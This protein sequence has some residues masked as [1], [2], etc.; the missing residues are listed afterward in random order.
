MG[1]GRCSISGCVFVEVGVYREVEGDGGRGDTACVLRTRRPPLCHRD[2][3]SCTR[4]CIAIGEDE[5]APV[6]G[7]E[8]RT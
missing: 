2:S 5:L 8:T 7:V 6:V 1:A 3:L 4:A